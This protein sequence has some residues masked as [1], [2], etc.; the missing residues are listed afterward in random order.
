MNGIQ[1]SKKING[2]KCEGWTLSHHSLSI[3]NQ[4]IHQD[5]NKRIYKWTPIFGHAFKIWME[6]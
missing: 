2:Q 3:H 1:K 6:I 4:N 5:Q